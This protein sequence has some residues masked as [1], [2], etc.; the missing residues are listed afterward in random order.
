M[1]LL[2]K[3][4]AKNAFQFQPD[5]SKSEY[6]NWLDYMGMAEQMNNGSY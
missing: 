2:S 6:D 5:F 4:F 3:L 1:G